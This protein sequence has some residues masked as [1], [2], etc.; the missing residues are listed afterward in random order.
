MRSGVQNASRSAVS[1]PSAAVP[2]SLGDVLGVSGALGGVWG[3]V[4]A[5]VFAEGAPVVLPETVGEISVEA[6]ADGDGL[7]AELLGD[8]DGVGVES[9]QA[10]VDMKVAAIAAVAARLRLNLML[11][12]S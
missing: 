10:A 9:A 5:P 1:V 7:V 11:P 8:V 4:G 2:L 12:P 3:V 6:E